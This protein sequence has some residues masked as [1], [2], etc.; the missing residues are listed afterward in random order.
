MPRFSWSWP[1][2]AAR[3]APCVVVTDYSAGSLVAALGKVDVLELEGLAVQD[4]RLPVGRPLPCG[5]VGEV[6]VVAQRLA[7]GGLVL[8]PEMPAAAL[9]AV[10]GVD[11]HELGQLDEVGHP[12]G[13]LEV[14]VEPAPVA[15]DLD[16]RPEL[17][18]ELGDEVQRLAQ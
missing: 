15:D 9:V 14:L 12:P 10:Q 8:G 2:L 18:L 17:P 13:V 11:A 16:V 1:A 3:V 4:R 7:L 6:L 5:G